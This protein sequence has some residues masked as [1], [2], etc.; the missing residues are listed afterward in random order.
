[1][2]AAE[3]AIERLNVWIVVCPASDPRDLAIEAPRHEG[4]EIILDRS[5][6]NS[7]PML[8]ACSVAAGSTSKP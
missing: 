7:V 2:I 6:K 1:M 3:Q 4:Y 8:T 5:A